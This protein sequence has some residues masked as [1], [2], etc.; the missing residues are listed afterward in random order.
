MPRR[1]SPPFGVLGYCI[2]IAG[3]C[4]GQKG[5]EILVRERDARIEKL[6]Q[7]KRDVARL[8]KQKLQLRTLLQ[9]KE[10]L[11]A[12]QIVDDEPTEIAMLDERLAAAAD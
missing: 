4:H 11:T 9:E 6:I 2:A 10:L 12:Q 1:L 3:A 5:F 7:A 8:K